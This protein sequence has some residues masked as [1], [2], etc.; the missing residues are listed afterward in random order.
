MRIEFG[1][2]EVWWH[3]DHTILAGRVHESDIILGDVFT[4]LAWT[5]WLSEPVNGS[6]VGEPTIRHAITLRVEGIEAYQR[7]LD[8]LPSGMTGALKLTGSGKELLG[9]V[10]PAA[11][12]GAWLLLGERHAE[13]FAPADGGRD[14][15][16]S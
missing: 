4:E 7:K 10:D 6:R 9:A 11:R 12:D 5:P 8:F 13:Q 14:A 2:D 15:G 16:S 3:P 1:A